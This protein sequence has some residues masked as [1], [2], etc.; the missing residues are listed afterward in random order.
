[1]LIPQTSLLC[2]S[3]LSDLLAQ[4]SLGEAMRPSLG[5]N[6]SKKAK[7]CLH[8]SCLAE[9]PLPNWHTAEAVVPILA[10]PGTM[11][12]CSARWLYPNKAFRLGPHWILS[13]WI[14]F[15]KMKMGPS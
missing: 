5:L 12:E 4:S 7:S 8:D 6:S 15:P 11:V 10:G 1:M 13:L 14:C 3:L 2:G 9:N